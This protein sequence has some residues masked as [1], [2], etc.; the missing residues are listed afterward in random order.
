MQDVGKEVWSGMEFLS[1]LGGTSNDVPPF[2]TLFLAHRTKATGK[3]WVTRGA[4]IRTI[5]LAGGR[6]VGFSGFTDLFDGFDGERSWSVSEWVT[7]LTEAGNTGDDALRKIAVAIGVESLKMADEGDWIVRFAT[8]MSSPT[9]TDFV[10]INLMEVSGEVV[11]Q[12]QAESK[13]RQWMEGLPGGVMSVRRPSDAGEPEWGLDE[14]TLKV[15]NV[16]DKAQN[17]GALYVSLAADDWMHV[18]LLWCLGLI[19]S[20]DVAERPASPAKESR[21]QP[22]PASSKLDDMNT[23]E[24]EAATTPSRT[25]EKPQEPTRKKSAKE[26]S[27]GRS[28]SKR[29]RRLSPRRMAIRRSPWESPPEEMEQ[30]L[31]EAYE[32]LKQ[33]RPEY[34]F[35]IRTTKDLETIS[36]ERQYRESCARYHPDKYSRESHAVRSLAEACFTLVAEAFHR[37]EVAEYVDPLRIRL[38]EKETG[39]KVVTDK[40]RQHAQVEFAKG[41]VLFRQKR[42]RDALALAEDAIAGD[43]DQWEYRYLH[44]KAGYRSG[45]VSIADTSK[46]ILELQGTNSIEKADTLYTLGE[47]FLKEG[48]DKKAYK[49]FQNALMCDPQNVG[50]RRRLRLRE[51]RES[52]VQEKGK[53]TGG[54]L[55]GLFQRRKE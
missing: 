17:V 52:V 53:Q 2:R 13:V 21:P 20:A 25:K 12:Y 27:L 37:L 41:T 18:A 46:A 34:I 9:V 50:A 38:V 48:D 19:S 24:Y 26:R 16:V 32:V 30:H 49:M 4:N 40:T 43:P 36:I 33:A 22:E 14:Q 55:G 35:R 45:D 51:R 39:Q 1:T 10:P 11:N 42:Y 29:K 54:F 15:L 3:L 7:A 5:D 44:A 6:L 47:F 31:R 28:S 8:D 23:E